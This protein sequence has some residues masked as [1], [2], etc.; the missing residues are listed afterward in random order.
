MLLHC[1]PDQEQL[2][3]TARRHAKVGDPIVV[4]TPSKTLDGTLVERSRT[5]VKV[6]CFA[7]IFYSRCGRHRQHTQV[8]WKA[9]NTRKVEEEEDVEIVRSE[10]VPRIS[11]EAS[12]IPAL[13]FELQRQTAVAK[14]FLE[15]APRHQY[16]LGR[17][18]SLQLIARYLEEEM[19]EQVR[20]VK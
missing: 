20:R 12:V 8:S 6:S 16:W 9:K 11:M 3:E 19:G 14:A 7:G 15:E 18:E 1:R 4:V 2:D 17:L 10:T 5:H 13:L